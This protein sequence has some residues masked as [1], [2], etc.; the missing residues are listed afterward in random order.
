MW[1]TFRASGTQK[2]R[3]HQSLKS[4]RGNYSVPDDVPDLRQVYSDLYKEILD[5]KLGIMEVHIDSVPEILIYDIDIPV[6]IDEIDF[7]IEE[8]LDSI[9]EFIE[10]VV[11]II[12]QVFQEEIM[13]YDPQK[14]HV[15]VCRRVN[16][17]KKKIGFH[18]YVPDIYL[19]QP[20]RKYIFDRIKSSFDQ[21]TEVKHSHIWTGYLDTEKDTDNIL[22]DCVVKKPQALIVYGGCKDDNV[23]YEYWVSY[24]TSTT[25]FH[26][27]DKSDSELAMM[28]S[29]HKN[30]WVPEEDVRINKLIHPHRAQ[31][32]EKK[33]KKKTKD[34]VAKEE[35]K[36]IADTGDDDAHYKQ[37][38]SKARKTTTE[39]KT[40]KQIPLENGTFISKSK[41][42]QFIMRKRGTVVNP[43]TNQRISVISPDFENV[44]QYLLKYI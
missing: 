1:Q 20:E 4:P 21:D 17:T 16:K 26:P 39:L 23:P 13:D 36:E 22:D 28:F 34:V 44:K 6:R 38:I 41:A 42:K 40:R 43:L 25:P 14:H 5:K 10:I 19:F 24:K 30:R 7:S 9:T 29:I 27:Q 32:G 18:L 37:I 8:D 35:S 31:K 3:T 33:P 11:K 12:V 15:H 2:E